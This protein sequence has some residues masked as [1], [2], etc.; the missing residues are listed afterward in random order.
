MP[1]R[2]SYRFPQRPKPGIRP[3]FPFPL[4]IDPRAPVVMQFWC[5]VHHDPAS[6]IEP[7]QGLPI[8]LRFHAFDANRIAVRCAVRLSKFQ[9]LNELN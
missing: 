3:P 6:A 9:E 4:E 5:L 7:H 2:P 8:Q 1:K